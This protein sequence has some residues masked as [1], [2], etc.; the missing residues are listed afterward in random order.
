MN[1]K[2]KQNILPI[3]EEDVFDFEIKKEHKPAEIKNLSDSSVTV[4]KKSS[5]PANLPIMEKMDL[6][7]NNTKIEES[8]SLSDNIDIDFEEVITK[9]TTRE[10]TPEEVKA[11]LN[12]L[13][14]GGK[15]K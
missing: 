13:L 1:G 7:E 2:S 6:F 14:S 8:D 15:L 4:E 3:Q 9:D 11:R 5:A 12:K 10:A